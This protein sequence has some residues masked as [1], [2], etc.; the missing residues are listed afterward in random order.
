MFDGH[1]STSILVN[2]TKLSLECKVHPKLHIISIT[3]HIEFACANYNYNKDL[4]VIFFIIWNRARAW[5]SC[6]WRLEANTVCQKYCEKAVITSSLW[7]INLHAIVH[8]ICSHKGF[9]C[10]DMSLEWVLQLQKQ[11]CH[12]KATTFATNITLN[13][14]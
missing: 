13:K 7:L 3:N 5:L 12:S 2:L 4:I 1:I 6:I 14:V 9:L 10:L 11:S 8:V